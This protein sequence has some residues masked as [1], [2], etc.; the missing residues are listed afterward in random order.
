MKKTNYKSLSDGNVLK[1]LIQFALPFLLSGFMQMA[2]SSVDV[3]FI[4][5]FASAGAVSGVSQG[6]MINAVV[7]YIFLGIA[8]GGTIILGQS[9]GAK[10]DKRSATV[11]GNIIS[12]SVI[13]VIITTLILSFFGSW[14]IKVMQ[15]P[16]EAVGEAQDYLNV[17]ICGLTFVM[18][19]NVVSSVLRSLGDSKAPF[20]FIVISSLLNILLDYIFV[21]V[22]KLSA[23]GAALAT[24]T[25]QGVSFIL[26]LIYIKVKGLPFP[27]N[28]REIIP[29]KSMIWEILKVGIPIS[30]QSTLN[31]L[32]FMIV[33]ALINSMGVF[34]SAANSIVGTITGLCMIVPMSFQSAVSAI[35]AQN[36]GAGQPQRAK[37]T[38]KYGVIISF[39]FSL[40][41]VLVVT[42]WPQAVVGILTK[43][44]D[45]IRESVRYLY[46]Y[47]WDCL[48][49]PFVFCFNGFFNGC[50][51]TLFAMVQEALAAFCV[52]IPASILL[53]VLIPNATIFHVGIGTPLASLASAIACIIYFRKRFSDDKLK[54]M[55]ASMQM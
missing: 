27:F 19:Y 18:G 24:V 14:I 40:V 3:F 8:M 1:V 34:V 22:L 42:F 23:K 49:V 7:T 41:F 4:G 45:V 12:L 30:L 25:A 5:R 13:A 38:L 43:D 28:A 17:C 53:K 51:K 2:Y 35:T 21:G 16:P 48:I 31:N 33:G 50:G 9:V 37:R 26:S 46:P 52:R 10:N 54:D 32:S 11:T 20:W 29:N 55:S 44:P 39:I 6:L 15:V 36:I 47:S